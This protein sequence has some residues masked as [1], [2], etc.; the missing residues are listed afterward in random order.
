[1]RISVEGNIG[2]G[3]STV[4]RALVWKLGVKTHLEPVEK[5]TKLL[6]RFYDNPKEASMDLQVRVMLDFASIVDSDDEVHIVERS[7][8][9]SLH[10]FGSI[11]RDKEW[12]SDSQWETLDFMKKTVGW[13]ADAV[14]FV[15]T[16]P[17]LCAERIT[18]RSGDNHP[19]E[20]KDLIYIQEVA[21]KY[22]EMIEKTECEVVVIDGTK[23]AEDVLSDVVSSIRRL[24]G[25]RVDI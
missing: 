3:K 8:S 5:W 12:I 2:S 7:P 17:E 10:V 1:M 13:D 20:P 21:S 23:S 19:T 4:M 6:E 16:P 18:K 22:A 24:V 9:A 14:I 11:S 15:D 25:G